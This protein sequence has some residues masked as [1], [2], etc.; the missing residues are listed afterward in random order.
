M[1]RV[2][3]NPS[4][5]KPSQS[6]KSMSM[7]TIAV[8]SAGTGLSELLDEVIIDGVQVFDVIINTGSA[9]LMLTAAVYKLL[10]SR[11]LIR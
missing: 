5:P 9:F 10:P 4:T 6:S 1:A 2:F 3:P 7:S 8:V 11:P